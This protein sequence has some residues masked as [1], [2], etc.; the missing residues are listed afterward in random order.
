MKEINEGIQST[1]YHLEE[2]NPDQ[3]A[4]FIA[5]VEEHLTRLHLSEPLSSG[6]IIYSVAAASAERNENAERNADS[7]ES[8]RGDADTVEPIASKL[9]PIQW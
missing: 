1:F 9:L 4:Q 2:M 5:G 8:S 3:A 7:G 6:P